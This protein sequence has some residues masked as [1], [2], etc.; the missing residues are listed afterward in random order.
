ME[1][2]GKKGGEEHQTVYKLEGAGTNKVYI[3]V[4]LG[5]CTQYITHLKT[6]D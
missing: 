4:V 6:R 2:I 3:A 1:E 5:G